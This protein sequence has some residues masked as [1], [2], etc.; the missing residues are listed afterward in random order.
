ML[1]ENALNI[2]TDGCS[3]GSPRRGGVGVRYVL[4]DSIGQEE[5]QDAQFPGY[6]VATNNQME[7]MAATLALEEAMRLRLTDQATSI[8]IYTDSL[9]VVDSVPKAM[10]EWPKTRWHLRSGRPVLNADLWKRLTSA[11]KKVGKRVDFKWVKGHA[12]SAHNKAADRMARRSALLPTNKPLSAVQVRRKIT[13]QSVDIGSV[14]MLGQRMSIHVF[15]S[16]LLKPQ[17]VWKCKYEVISKAS[18]YFGLVDIIFS[19][20]FLTAGHSYFVLVNK[21]SANP[22][23]VKVFRELSRK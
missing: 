5:L 16:E 3:L 13:D 8:F 15:V 18:K 12:K 2:F 1:R 10:F 4:V 9:Y 17:N 7:L 23:V 19:D 11:M 20:H 22:R 21:E 14:Q 6:P